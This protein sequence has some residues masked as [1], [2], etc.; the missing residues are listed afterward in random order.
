MTGPSTVRPVKHR[1][2]GSGTLLREEWAVPRKVYH[3][4]RVVRWSWQHWRSVLAVFVVWL[5]SVRFGPTGGLLL[6]ACLVGGALTWWLRSRRAAIGDR[7][8]LSLRDA[9]D[10]A[11]QR[12]TLSKQ[13]SLACLAAGLTGPRGGAVPKLQQV[14]AKG[15]GTFSALVDSG[16]IGVPTFAMEK[17]TRD[18]AEVIG[19]REVVVTQVDSGKA[20]IDF[21]WRDPI[22]RVLP[23][24]ALPA[25]PKGQLAY[26]IR[27]DGSVAAIRSNMSVLIGGLTRRGKSNAVWALLADA[28]RTN[29]PVRL[30]VSDPKGGVELNV[31]EAMLGQTGS[32]VEVRQ[33]AKTPAET[34]KM[35]E[36]LEG[37]MHAR[38][39]WMT[40]AKVRQVQPDWENP[41]VVLILDET[42][43]LT[44][45]LKRGTDSALG[46][47]AYT[48]AAAGYVVWA[49]TQ[50]AQID[51]IGRFRD[52]VPQ[53]ICFATP[54]PQVTDSVL[55]QGA[56]AAGARCSDIKLAGVGFSYSEDQSHPR[57]F[58]AAF[59]TDEE[60]RIIAAGKVPQAMVDA[61]IEDKGATLYRWY[62]KDPDAYPD[63]TLGY[64]G[65]SY[66]VLRREAEHNA[67][68]RAFMEGEKVTR[69]AEQWPS[70]KL[71][72]EAERRAIE[73][74][75]PLYNRQHNGRNPNR[76]R[77]RKLKEPRPLQI[78]DAS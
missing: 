66:D 74:E 43:P 70:R 63:A 76:R 8:A 15:D 50:V 73:T 4:G 17:K 29:T 65:I 58:R 31:L 62:D 33:Y 45:L 69:K 47:I 9:M 2:W 75:K 11:R 7:G 78:V 19:C 20:R 38:Q 28:I 60:T 71:A 36:A 3:L 56:E 21:H 23:L 46:R 32:L 61:E 14:K 68:A 77:D 44:D 34:V 41:L 12:A 18:L 42:L 54:N 10:E 35:I 59:V 67:D 52:L 6:T 5:L 53:R 22:G 55:G 57:K 51:S 40:E 64:V 26:G 27:Q 37:A 24:V 1:T 49:C 16:R 30:Y 13:W 25:A 72:L 48:G 39:R